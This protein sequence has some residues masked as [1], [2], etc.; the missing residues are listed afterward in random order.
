M[1]QSSSCLCSRPC[2]QDKGP[3]KKKE[4]PRELRQ[5]P[6]VLSVL[7]SG[8]VYLEPLLAGEPVV[9]T[10]C[11]FGVVRTLE[12]DRLTHARVLRSPWSCLPSSLWEAWW[13]RQGWGVAGSG[14][15]PRGAWLYVRAAGHF[16]GHWC[17]D[18]SSSNVVQ[19]S[20]PPRQ[21]PSPQFQG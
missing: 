19:A 1:A 15:T 17:G 10:V 5:D 13:A 8:L 20:H 9:S 3:K 2:P 4:P 16:A 12:T 6:P 18:I 7:G 11:N 14:G 21:A